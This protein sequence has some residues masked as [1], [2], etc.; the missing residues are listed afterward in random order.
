MRRRCGRT[1]SGS[2]A[3]PTAAGGL[4][5]AACPARPRFRRARHPRPRLRRLAADVDRQAQPAGE[6]SAAHQGR[7][8]G[9]GDGTQRAD[10]A[11]HSRPGSGCPGGGSTRTS[12]RCR[13]Q[14]LHCS[15]LWLI[16]LA[17]GAGRR[18]GTR[19]PLLETAA[20]PGSKLR[21]LSGCCATRLVFDEQKPLH[22]SRIRHR[23]A[24]VR[25]R[26]ERQ[27]GR[28]RPTRRSRSP[29]AR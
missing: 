12:R 19:E 7:H 14:G 9:R 5:T 16:P 6:G 3:A 18:H 20:A 10:R 21:I 26:S 25:S 29:P 1:S 27:R 2:S 28:A 17:V 23:R 13:Q 4:A 24:P 8:V 11:S 22:R 15:G